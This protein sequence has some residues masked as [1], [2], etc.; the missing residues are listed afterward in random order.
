MKA[1]YIHIPF[2]SNICSYCDF[3]KVFYNKKW[4]LNYLNVLDYEIKSNYRG[5]V[6]DTIYIGGGTPSSLDLEELERL[7]QILSQFQVSSSLEYTIECNLENLT[8]E[9]ILLFKK[10]GINRLS[11]G[12]QTFQDQFLNF[13]NRKKGDISLIA[14]AKEIGISN[15]NIDLI[16]ALPNQTLDD[17]E[18]DLE[19]FLNL[20]ITH[21]STY[22]LMIEP[23]TVLYNKK[24]NSIDEELDFNMYQLICDTL[25]KNGFKHYETSNF[26]K[27]G[28]ESKHNL[29]Y[30]H[31]KHYYGFGLGASGYIDNVRYTNTRSITKYLNYEFVQ[32]KEMLTKQDE[33]TYEMILGLRKIEGV[34][35]NHFYRK[36]NK[37]VEEVFD[38]IDLIETKKLIIENGYMKINSDYLYVSNDILVRFVGD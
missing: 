24:V 10:Y 31:N 7:F 27:I 17:L 38:I 26:S 19:A 14:F 36:F 35:L 8:K 5:E 23:N 15:I 6:L 28:F 12:I 30:W 1:A 20:D 4:V 13:L 9:K 22:S 11:I 18:K 29:N 2:C 21:I 25:E 3:A 37:Q 32:E 16:Y 34:D 33:M